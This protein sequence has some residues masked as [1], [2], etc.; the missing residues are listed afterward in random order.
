M[1][2]AISAYSEPRSS[3]GPSAAPASHGNVATLLLRALADTLQQRG[4][5]PESLLGQSTESLYAE[6][7]DRS[8]PRVWFQSM[9]ARAIELTADPA[10]GIYCGLY[11][12]DSSFG[13]MAPLIA[14][15]HSLRRG[16]ELVAQFHPLLVEGCRIEL[17]EQL[18]VA[19]MRCELEQVG[20][21]D[22]SF[23]ELVVAGL[24]R[25]LHAFGCGK[26]E[27]RAVCFE[28]ARP[29]YHHAYTAA[30]SGKER[31]AQSFTGI[32][33]DASALD[34]PHLHRIAELHEI[35]LA[36]AEHNLQRCTRPLTLT[37]RVTALINSRP[38]AKLPD[39]VAAARELGIS[40]RSLRRH[41]THE[42]TTYRELTQAKLHTSACSLLRNPQFSLQSIAFELGFS[43]A[44]AFHRAFRRWSNVT[45]AEY[46]NVFLS[47]THSDSAQS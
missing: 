39:M 34:R 28:H 32:E 33:F 14:H 29:S 46:R 20:A 21:G 1:N 27:L 15:A 16:L 44:T 19:R 3:Y 22:R 38:A 24:A 8:V 4:V 13:L 30:F 5:A 6:P 41:L 23:S 17:T 47:S 10:L 36:Q 9:F 42:G 12:T 31:F 35:V 45:P 40:V 11:A 25:M 43:D 18:G 7:V 37:E 26:H 2:H